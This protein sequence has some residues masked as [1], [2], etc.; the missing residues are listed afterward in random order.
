LAVP[1]T[2]AGAKKFVV[3]GISLM[4]SRDAILVLLKMEDGEQ[5]ALV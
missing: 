5:R 2:A 4:K 3:S 1:A